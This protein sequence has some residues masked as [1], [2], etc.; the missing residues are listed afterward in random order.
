MEWGKICASKNGGKNFPHQKS[1]GKFFPTQNSWGNFSPK[2]GEKKTLIRYPNTFRI[3]KAIYSTML[4]ILLTPIIV[5]I[6]NS[7]SKLLQSQ[8]TYFIQVPYG[9]HMCPIWEQP[10]NGKVDILEGPHEKILDEN[11]LQMRFRSTYTY[12]SKI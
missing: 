11:F 9:T 5:K 10:E 2:M 1:W 6:V 3:R 8:P 12:L 4:S 7:C